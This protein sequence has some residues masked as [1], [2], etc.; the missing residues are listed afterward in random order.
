MPS[1]IFGIYR[2][3]LKNYLDN[4]TVKYETF[5]PWRKN[6]KFIV[7]HSFRVEEYT[8]QII[9][10]DY[11]DLNYKSIRNI[12]IASILHDIGRIHGR[13]NHAKIGREIV[14][15][16][17]GK[18]INDLE[19]YEIDEILY[20]I[21]NHSF[22]ENNIENLCLN[23]LQDA[24]LLD[25]IG[26]MSLFMASNLIDKNDP[27]FFNN[28]SKRFEEKEIDFCEKTF[29]ILKTK[30]ARIILN[31]KKD[32]IHLLNDQL[33]NEIKGTENLFFEEMENNLTNAST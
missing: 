31:K 3:F 33:K 29:S 5:H 11:N 4:K 28:L 21:E 23:I 12:K 10:A 22:K 17:F 26:V 19:Q 13:E 9:N 16:W 2:T 14:K 30:Q 6:G 15:S 25:E 24:D 20:L 27:F 18:N 8:T 1:D 32:F 7:L